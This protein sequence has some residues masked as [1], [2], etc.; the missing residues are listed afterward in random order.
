MNRDIEIFRD[1]NFSNHSDKGKNLKPPIYNKKYCSNKSKITSGTNNIG[2]FK[3]SFSKNKPRCFSKAKNH[4]P[5]AQ[6]PH[7]KSLKLNSPSIGLSTQTPKIPNFQNFPNSPNSSKT[8]KSLKFLI[9]HRKRQGFRDSS[10]GLKRFRVL[11]MGKKESGESQ[12]EREQ[13]KLPEPSV[14]RLQAA[15]PNLSA[16]RSLVKIGN[17]QCNDKKFSKNIQIKRVLRKSSS[18]L[19]AREHFC[20]YR[21]QNSFQTPTKMHLRSLQR[22]I[23]DEDKFFKKR[24]KDFSKIQVQILKRNNNSQEKKQDNISFGRYGKDGIVHGVSLVNIRVGGSK[25]N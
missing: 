4:P 22:T 15:K 19:R 3:S 1:L 16:S 14:S 12:R 23:I 21:K 7:K 9:L 10:K 24:L 2:Q 17:N 25:I 5:T 8:P 6:T 11:K 20:V 18:K 13:L